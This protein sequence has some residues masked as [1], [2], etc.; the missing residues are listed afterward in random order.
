VCEAII[1]TATTYVRGTCRTWITA[2]A[3]IGLCLVH[4]ARAQIYVANGASGT[5]GVYT[6]GGGTVNASLIS[7]LNDPL[8]LDVELTPEPSSW[9]LLFGGL[10]AWL[11]WRGK[12]GAGNHP[13]PNTPLLQHSI[14]PEP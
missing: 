7:G 14:S 11:I 12:R 5:V 3:L 13:F 10:G 2:T 9:A 4:A 1:I 6:T 8:G